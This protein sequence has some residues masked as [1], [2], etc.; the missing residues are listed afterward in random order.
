MGQPLDA[1]LPVAGAFHHQ[2]RF[3]QLHEGGVIHARPGQIL[4]KDGAQAGARQIGL[5]LV[6][7]DAEAVFADRVIQRHG[8]IVAPLQRLRQTQ[9]L[10]RVAAPALLFQHC[11]HV[12]QDRVAL[13]GRLGPQI[14]V[15]RGVERPLQPVVAQ[16]GA[17]GR[18]AAQEARIVRPQRRIVAQVDR[19]AQMGRGGARIARRFRRGGQR[20]VVFDR[21]IAADV[22]PAQ[23]G[24]LIAHPV[25]VEARQETQLCHPRL[26]PRHRGRGR[27]DH[28]GRKGALKEGRRPRR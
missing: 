2:P 12:H 20:K 25:K 1:Q 6:F 21:Q 11:A 10:H 23:T 8:G 14:G 7:R 13:R 4:G 17:A 15:D 18:L 16:I 22:Q 28:A 5:H 9:R 19:G 3:G 24:R 26:R 27:L